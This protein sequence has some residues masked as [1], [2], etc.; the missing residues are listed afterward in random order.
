MNSREMRRLGMSRRQLFEAIEQPVMRAPPQDDFEYAEW[1]LA[2]VG[3]DYHVVRSTLR[4][5]R[6]RASSTRCRTP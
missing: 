1:H 2:R 6:C 4:M 3:I 5:T